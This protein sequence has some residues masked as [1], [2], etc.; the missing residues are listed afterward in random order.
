VLR[1]TNV[2]FCVRWQVCQV[3]MMDLNDR[4]AGGLTHVMLVEPM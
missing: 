1:V 4:K 2:W 3:E